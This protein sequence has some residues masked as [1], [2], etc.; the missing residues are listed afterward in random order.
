[1]VEVRAFINAIW[2]IDWINYFKLCTVWQ[3]IKSTIVVEN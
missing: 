1:M 2:L 3:N